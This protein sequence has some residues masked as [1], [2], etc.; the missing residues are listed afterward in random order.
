LVERGLND[1]YILTTS[2]AKYVARIYRAGWRSHTDIAYELELLLHLAANRVSVSAPIA[3]RNGT[4]THA[5]QTPEG[6]RLLALFTYAAGRPLKWRPDQAY[7]AGKLLSAVHEATQNFQS[8]HA[9]TGFDL[10]NLIDI[11]LARIEPFLDDRPADRA[12]L[13]RFASTLRAAAVARIG[14]AFEWGPV[15][16]DYGA[17]NVHLS[18]HGVMTVFDFDFCGPGWRMLDLVVFS[19]GAASKPN[20]GVWESFLKGY[21]ETRPVQDSDLAAVPLFQALHHFWG[22]GLRACSAAQHG[23]A[24]ISSGYLNYRIARFKEWEEQQLRDGIWSDAK[25]ISQPGR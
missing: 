16:G 3:A 10:E 2:T 24:H 18:D 19:W 20:R 9:R 13:R 15:H 21:R 23:S 22:M 8:R 4:L 5:V 25:T 12:F 7:L 14:D 1:T 11:P 6:G 17:N